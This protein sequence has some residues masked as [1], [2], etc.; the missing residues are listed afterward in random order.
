MSLLPGCMTC[1]QNTSHSSFIT[2]SYTQQRR[3]ISNL[4]QCC[5]SSGNHD[6]RVVDQSQRRRQSLE[7]QHY[8]ADGGSVSTTSNVV[9]SSSSTAAAATEVHHVDQS[10]SVWNEYFMDMDEIVRELHGLDDDIEDAVKKEDYGTA[11]ALKREQEALESQDTVLQIQK[12][13]EAAIREERYS[14]AAVLRDL[15]GVRLLG[16]WVGREGSHD[17]QGHVIAITRDFSRYVAHAFTGYTLARA[18]GWMDESSP[19]ISLDA[20]MMTSVDDDDAEEEDAGTPVFEVFY[21][22]GE[23][24]VGWKHQAAV[25]NS[26]VETV[27][28][29]VSIEHGMDEDGTDFVKINLAG[30]VAEEDDEHIQTVEDLVNSLEESDE[31]VEEDHIADEEEEEEEEEEE[32]LDDTM[33]TDDLISALSDMSHALSKRVPADIE[34]IDRDTFS[35]VVDEIKQQEILHNPIGLTE[36]ENDTNRNLLTE[37]EHSATTSALQDDDDDDD[38][39]DDEEEPE[40]LKEIETMVKA[41]LSSADPTVNIMD[42]VQERSLEPTSSIAGLEGKVTYTRLVAPTVTTDVFQGLYLGSFGPHGPEILEIKRVKLDGQE[43]VHGVKITG[44]INVPAGEMSFKARVGREH[45]LSPDG[46]YPIEYGVQARYPGQGRVAREGYS[47][48]KWVDG[49]L[50]TLTKSNALTRGA[51]VGFVF[52]VDASKK[53]LLLFERIDDSIFKDY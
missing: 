8:A 47:S 38:D 32:K 14:D 29:V 49:E 10:W 12:D 31:M 9:A 20:V 40:T 26:P 44:D 42:D 15:G 39:G 16:W 11:A 6:R 22:Q 7:Q 23:D 53:F 34:W 25:F 13:L 28:N 50:L 41:A 5:S 27:G 30:V 19:E 4:L 2:P 21:R 36:E 43:W 37:E 48:P 18:V 45:R 17:A 3:K 24:K 35:L 52:H 46:V 1:L 33:T 51:E